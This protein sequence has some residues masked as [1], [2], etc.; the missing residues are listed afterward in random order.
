MNQNLAESLAERLKIAV[1]QVVREEFEL[2]LLKSLFESGI[3]KALVFKGGTALRIAFGSPRFSDD[4]DFYASFAIPEAA[5]QKAARAALKALPEASLVE[6]LAKRFTLF[7]LYRFNVPYIAR[8][9]S[10]KVEVSTREE[11]RRQA[12]ESEL[13]LLSSEVTNLSVLARVATLERALEDKKAAFA[14]RR[15]PRDLYDLWFISQK[16]GLPFK[17]DLAGFDPRIV[18]RELR[19]YLPK[20]HWSVI[21]QWTG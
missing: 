10:I 17:A 13:R 16:L 1:E 8:P 14:A 15:Q 7:A 9:F 4:L 6:A 12:D 3:G 20:A 5:F 2:S 19:K 11:S 21:D 18:R